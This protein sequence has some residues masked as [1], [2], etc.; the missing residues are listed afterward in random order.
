MPPTVNPS[1]LKVGWAT[2][3]GETKILSR[4]KDPVWIPPVSVRREHAKDGDILPAR[5]PDGPDNPLGRHLF[6]PGWPALPVPGT[7]KP[8]G[9][10]R[11]ARRGGHAG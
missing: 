11:G 10:G 7:Y 4:I 1:S 9:V 5:V 6:R 3:E 2:P 8:Y